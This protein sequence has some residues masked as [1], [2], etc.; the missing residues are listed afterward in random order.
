[1]K[2]QILENGAVEFSC[3]ICGKV[4]D[5][6]DEGEVFFADFDA[7]LADVTSAD[8]N[9]VWFLC[10]K[11]FQERN[12]QAQPWFDDRWRKLVEGGQS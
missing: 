8:V 9:S 1:M 6:E 11:C 12:G 4:L 7:F 5:A 3:D 2:L 10:R